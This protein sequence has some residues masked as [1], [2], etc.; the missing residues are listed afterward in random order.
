MIARQRDILRH[1]FAAK[2]L[3]SASPKS[4][5]RLTRNQQELHAVT[6]EFAFGASQY[7]DV[8]PLFDAADAMQAAVAAL[9]QSDLEVGTAAEQ[10]ALASLIRA[11]ENLRK[12]LKQSSS[13][14]SSQCRS[15]DKQQ[16]QKLRTP[17]QQQEQQ[18][19]QVAQTRSQLE[20]LAEQQRQWS[21]DVRQCSSSSQ[22]SS[23]SQSQS[24]SQSSQS[25][26][27]S[28]SNSS[29]SPS[30]SSSTSSPDP[31]QLAQQQR[32]ALGKVKDVQEQLQGSNMS[33]EQADQQLQQAAD[34]VQSSLDRLAQDEHAAAAADAD[35]AADRLEE[36]SR[37]LA[38]LNA[39]DFAERLGHAQRLAQQLA[40][41]QAALTS[42]LQAASNA[43]DSKPGS[44][45]NKSGSGAPS[46]DQSPG[47]EAKL[48]EDTNPGGEVQAGGNGSNSTG[49]ASAG[50]ANGKGRPAVDKTVADEQRMLAERADF[51]AELIAMLGAD[52]NEADR[53]VAEIIEN[54]KSTNPP[55]EIADVMRDAADDVD[56]GRLDRARQSAGMAGRS[57]EELAAGLRQARSRQSQPN[58]EELI[59]IEQQIADLMAALEN[60][61]GQ[62]EVDV[63]KAK[64]GQL[65]PKVEKMARGDAQLAD[66]ARSMADGKQAAT[67][68][69]SLPQG[70]PQNFDGSR[71]SPQDSGWRQSQQ[72]LAG[73]LRDVS[74]ALQAKIQEA[75]LAGALL[76]ADQGVPPGYKELVEAY[77][78]A[79]SDDLR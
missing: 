28:S 76:D 29:G 74:K 60:A 79:L 15:F 75:I 71:Q 5:D 64:A 1:T 4:I 33:G 14:S 78:R 40:E 34:A 11:R 39:A 16:R 30:T 6:T 35:Q 48:G 44:D 12:I 43:K 73:G 3:G 47:G 51:L 41:R 27:S 32:D 69:N 21:Q 42:Q 67:G 7:G 26:S 55:D 46:S 57:L 25:Q 66:A 63:A 8:Q 68:G 54:A 58:L 72:A 31:Q 45:G 77:Y 18:Q 61:Q 2:E 56:D 65:Q 52:S 20:Q 17:E 24:Q 10:S 22:Q 23:Q 53:A 62:S 70:G 19:Q 50:S 38:A 36:I 49:S 13:S 9:E 59:A 37:Q